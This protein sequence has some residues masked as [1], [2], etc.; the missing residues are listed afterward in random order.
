MN[1]LEWKGEKGESFFTKDLNLLEIIYKL[2]RAKDSDLSLLLQGETGTG[3]DL[4]A[5]AIHFTSSRKE[6]NFVA[7]NC[8]AFPETLLESE[9]FGHKKGSFTG[10][11]EDKEGLIEVA[12]GGTL[13]L[14]EVADVPLRLQVKLLRALEEKD[15]TKLGEVKP[16]KVDFRL[17]A[18]T[19]KDLESLIAQGQFRSDLFY[20]I[21]TMQF[22]LPPLRERLDIIELTHFFVETLKVR[23][24]IT[25]QFSI[26]NEVLGA[27]Q[28]YSWPG[29]T[30]Q[31]ENIIEQL[32]ILSK[33]TGQ[34]TVKLL[35]NLSGE[36]QGLIPQ[37][38]RTSLEDKLNIYER[39]LII[40]A[41]E[42]SNWNQ[43]KATVELGVSES[44]LRNKMK[45]HKIKRPS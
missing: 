18:T 24:R 19:N 21:N 8:A 42:E 44:T 14:D 31:L 15:I 43:S 23:H 10:A 41:L 2:D 29:N 40:K 1:I 30:R 25:R 39:I 37:P 7:I 26:A 33:E 12:E 9:L 36:L 4:L 20:R 3:K 27:L 11:F 13:L 17:I 16:R 5:K 28:N 22:T 6:K 35:E 45:K 34:I 32:I 38:C